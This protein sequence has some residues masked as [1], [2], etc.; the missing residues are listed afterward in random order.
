M[1]IPWALGADTP[2]SAGLSWIQI[3]F[4]LAGGLTIFLLGMDFMSQAMKAVAGERLK[5]LLARFTRT[6]FSGVVAGTVVTSV[7]QSSSVTTVLVVGFVSAGLMNLS[8]SIAVIFGANIGTTITAQIVAF[9]VTDYALVM[10][11][12]GY[13]VM[14][15]GR[16]PLYR[17]CGQIVMGLGMVFLGMTL[18]GASTAPLRTYEPFQR[19]MITMQHPLLGVLVGAFFTA[20]VQSSSATTGI[21]IAFA[22]QGLISLSAGIALSLGA[23]IG[24]CA[25]A[26]LASIGKPTEALRVVVVHIIFNVAGVMIWIGLID[27][28]ALITTTVT[29]WMVSDSDSTVATAREIANAHTIFNVAN[30]LLF[31]GFVRKLERFVIWLVPQR[32]VVSEEI[33]PRYLDRG[34]LQTPPLA[35]DASRREIERMGSRLVQA[36]TMMVDVA[37][38]RDHGKAESV[39]R[40]CKDAALLYVAIMSYLRDIN[41]LRLDSDQAVQTQRLIESVVALDQVAALLLATANAAEQP[42]AASR[43]PFSADTLAQFQRITA[44]VSEQL[45]HAIASIVTQDLTRAQQVVDNKPA[46]QRQMRS[47]ATYLRGRLLADAPNRVT[48]FAQEIDLL[49]CLKRVYYHAKRACYALLETDEELELVHSHDD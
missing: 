27:Q 18:M 28:L 38:R 16:G 4:G 39:R 29:L 47:T 26:L 21:V 35:I 33:S 45:D 36:T 40:L 9:K 32:S 11:G 22:S 2:A 7:L 3:V 25:T 34:L 17:N 23:N 46:I 31:L 20:I 6:R 43:V 12:V 48:T 37:G 8:Q 30:T 5:G 10:C 15:L 42:S 49:E 24:T 13:P 1:T 44:A 14:M 19:M 41:R